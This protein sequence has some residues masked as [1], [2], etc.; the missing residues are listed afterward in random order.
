MFKIKKGV[1]T[2]GLKMEMAPALIAANESYRNRKAHCIITSAIDGRHSRSS[3]HYTGC[4]VDL[5]TRHL[6]PGQAEQI[7]TELKEALGDDYDV[8]L[9]KDHIHL[10]YDPK[11]PY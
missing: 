4:A 10:E 9:E 1:R 5:R 11:E 7:V 8:V 2:H 6:F 3:K